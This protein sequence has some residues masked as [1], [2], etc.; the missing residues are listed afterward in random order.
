VRDIDF[1]VIFVAENSNKL[2]KSR[3][4]KE[5][6]VEDVVNTW[7][8]SISHTST[9]NLALHVTLVLFY[10]DKVNTLKL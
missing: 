7:A 5:K 4:W 1:Q 6:S 2:Q 9:I 3:F 8:N 10:I